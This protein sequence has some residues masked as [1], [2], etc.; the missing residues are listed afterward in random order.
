[1]KMIQLKVA[2]DK[3]RII[4]TC[5]NFTSIACALLP[6]LIITCITCVLLQVP[7]L[8]RLVTPSSAAAVAHGI[9]VI[10][11]KVAIDK[12]LI[13]ITCINYYLYYMCNIGAQSTAPGY[14]VL[15]SS[16][17]SRYQSDSAQ[18]GHR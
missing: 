9:K 14:P 7:S 10:R 15:C 11:L 12:R 13:I 2:V 5:I 18:G 8:Q 1:M 6:L 4:F 3:R 17:S 16:R